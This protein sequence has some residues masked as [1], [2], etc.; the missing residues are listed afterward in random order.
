MTPAPVCPRCRSGLAAGDAAL[1]CAS[2]GRTYPVALG[3]PDL[4]VSPDPYLEPEAD[5]ERGR[6]L[7][8]A[9][10][11]RDLAEL[12]EHYW[13]FTD[14]PAERVRRYVR[15]DLA[16]EA[17]GEAALRALESE[18]GQPIGAGAHVLDLGCRSGGL[19]LAAARR[20]ASAAGVDVAFRWLVIA[21]RRLEQQRLEASLVCACA[22]A[23]PFPDQSFDAV[24]AGNVLEHTPDPEGLLREAGRVL[25][26][27]GALL[28][29]TCNRFSLG[30]EP[31][32]RLWGVGFLPRALMDPYVRLRSGRPYLHV[33]LL[34]VF[35]LKR[36]A[37]RSFGRLR[38]RP[39]DVSDAEQ[40]GLPPGERLLLAAYR[41]L[42]RWPLARP[43]LLLLGPLLQLVCVRTEARA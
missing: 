9:G 14:E 18:T 2:C 24:V 1:S 16:S 36:L 43:L 42:R 28:A 21:D 37:A 8:E 17:R 6:A 13:S 27:G 23:L 32:V 25:R 15:H 33:R 31:H 29:V 3:I 22:Q 10:R 26:P 12:L 5:R 38:I 34:S 41:R 19:L 4:R 11:D 7:A 20:G 35:E 40:Q 39:A 30:P